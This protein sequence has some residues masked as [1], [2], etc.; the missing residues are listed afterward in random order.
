VVETL[1]SDRDQTLA[2]LERGVADRRAQERSLQQ[3]RDGLMARERGIEIYSAKVDAWLSRRLG[4]KLIVYLGR[5]LSS[6]SVEAAGAEQ[7]AAWVSKAVPAELE[8]VAFTEDGTFPT[9]EYKQG[10]INLPVV[11]RTRGTTAE[12][13]AVKL[14]P[15]SQRRTLSR[16]PTLASLRTRMRLPGSRSFVEGLL[17]AVHRTLRAAAGLRAADTRDLGDLLRAL[18]GCRSTYP[19]N[20]HP[21]P[22]PAKWFYLAYLGMFVGG[23]RVPVSTPVDEDPPKVQRL[24]E[25]ATR[26]LLAAVGYRPLILTIPGRSEHWR[27]ADGRPLRYTAVHPALFLGDWR[28]RLT[29]PERTLSCYEAAGRLMDQLVGMPVLEIRPGAVPAQNGP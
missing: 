5:Q 17:P 20:S 13:R 21:W 22:P 6:A 1:I 25:E 10:L 19:G 28:S 12:V 7:L 24:F 16:R 8:V 11:R 27:T 15:K 2:D 9:N 29:M 26:L 23:H 4:G 14:V 18:V 3:K